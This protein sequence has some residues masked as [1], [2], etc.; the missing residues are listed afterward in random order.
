MMGDD[1]RSSE[2]SSD[3]SGDRGILVFFYSCF[4]NTNHALGQSE[5][6]HKNKAPKSD[7]P[8]TAVTLHVM[9]AGVFRHS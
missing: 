1:G 8:Y 2:V 5:I 6:I 3:G 7:P 4:L 9:M